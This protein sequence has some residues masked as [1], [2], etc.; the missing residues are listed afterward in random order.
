MN[1]F[2]DLIR[3]NDFVVLDTETTGLNDG[4]ICQIAI[5]DHHGTTLIDTLV[6]TVFPIPVEATRIHGIT[7]DMTAHSPRWSEVRPRVLELL[8]GRNV[9]AYNADYDSKMLIKTDER[10]FGRSNAQSSEYVNWKTVAWWSCAMKAYA[11]FNGE[12]DEI[13]QNYKFVKLTDAARY[14]NVLTNHPHTAIEDA[15]MTLGVAKGLS[16]SWKK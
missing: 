11:E 8:K 14:F 16:D 5:I 3:G 12:W 10:S 4:E 6:K 1:D 7:N 9:V 13:Y 15:T 2:V